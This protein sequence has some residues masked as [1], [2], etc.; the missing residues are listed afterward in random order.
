ML[1]ADQEVYYFKSLSAWGKADDVNGY[2]LSE[3]SN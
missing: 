3:H 1:L 2:Y